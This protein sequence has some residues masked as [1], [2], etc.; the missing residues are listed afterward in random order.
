MQYSNKANCT[1]L[2][3]ACRLIQFNNINHYSMVQYS[4]KA[5]CTCL[6]PVCR[7]IQYNNI[8][9][10]SMV[11]YSNKANRTCLSP[12]CRLITKIKIHLLNKM[13][14]FS[15]K[16]VIFFQRV[17]A[18]STSTLLFFSRIPTLKTLFFK[19][20]RITRQNV[21]LSAFPCTAIMCMHIL[22][23][24]EVTRLYKTYHFKYTYRSLCTYHMYSTLSI[25]RPWII[26]FADY[27]C[28]IVSC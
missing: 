6:S 11:Q 27:P 14:D 8:N 24:W 22:L 19:E 15:E 4:N 9:H 5:N 7:L 18:C 17:Y 12:A 26:Q 10:Y 21:Y 3:P 28:T 25:I 16:I 1:C 13:H 20:I 2:S 23:Q